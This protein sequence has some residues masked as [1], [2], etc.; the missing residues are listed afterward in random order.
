MRR[1]LRDADLYLMAVGC[2]IALGWF[3][4][5]MFRLVVWYG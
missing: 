4:Y 2:L 1:L 5:E 3:V